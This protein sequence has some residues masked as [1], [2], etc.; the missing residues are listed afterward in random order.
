MIREHFVLVTVTLL[1]SVD[2]DLEGLCDRSVMTS[3]EEAVCKSSSKIV[4][5]GRSYA[6]VSLYVMHCAREKLDRRQWWL[7]YAVCGAPV[8]QNTWEKYQQDS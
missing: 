1:P 3:G 7:K 8:H 6:P 2:T 4:R 5:K